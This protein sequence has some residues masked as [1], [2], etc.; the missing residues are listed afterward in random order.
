G[1]KPQPPP[2]KTDIGLADRWILHELQSTTQQVTHAL[3]CYNPA[4]ASRTLYEFIWGSLCDW[5]LE[6]SKVALTGQETKARQIK[7]TLLVHLLQ[8]S[9]ALLHP[10]MPYETEALFQALRPYLSKPTDSLMISAWP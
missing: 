6:I 3:E 9:V 8:Q 7:Q 5:Y 2:P 10:I 4:E 1:S